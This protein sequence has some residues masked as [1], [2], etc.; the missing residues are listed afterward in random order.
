MF[1]LEAFFKVHDADFGMGYLCAAVDVG[2]PP[3]EVWPNVSRR[4]QLVRDVLRP[5]GGKDVV[6][7]RLIVEFGHALVLQISIRHLLQ[8]LVSPRVNPSKKESELVSH[9]A[10]L[11]RLASLVPNL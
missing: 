4:Q 9:V 11:S 8:T 10:F 7:R 1:H 2:R 5:P 3:E 6:E